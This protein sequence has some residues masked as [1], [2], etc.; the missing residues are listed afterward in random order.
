M[1]LMREQYT[2]IPMIYQTSLE[3]WLF[4]IQMLMSAGIFSAKEL[5]QE[6]KIMI[7]FLCIEHLFVIVKHI[8]VICALYFLVLL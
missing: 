6:S 5:K 8:S 1:V 2:Y 3:V 7:F 4:E